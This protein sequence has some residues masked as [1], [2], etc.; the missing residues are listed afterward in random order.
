MPHGCALSVHVLGASAPSGA[1]ARGLSLAAFKLPGAGATPARAC[2][3]PV[4]EILPFFERQLDFVCPVR[5]DIGSFLQA[6][7]LTTPCYGLVPV[8]LPTTQGPAWVYHTNTRPTCR[9]IIRSHHRTRI[10][11]CCFRLWLRA[12]LPSWTLDPG[13]ACAGGDHPGGAVRIRRAGPAGAQGP[14]RGGPRPAQCA[15][16]GRAAAQASP[17]LSLHYAPAPQHA[18]EHARTHC[19]FPLG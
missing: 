14:D 15:H 17:V 7:P 12:C 5:K 2:S 6:S 9:Q 19:F 18:R 16:L 11:A 13:C 4:S 1:P 3:G 10:F 8:G